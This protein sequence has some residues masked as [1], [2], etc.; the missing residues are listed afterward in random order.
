MPFIIRGVSLL[1]IALG[2]HRARHPRRIWEHLASD[3]KPPHLDTIC[4]R[5][6]TLDEL[7]DVFATHARGRLV[8]AYASCVTDSETVRLAS[9]RSDA[10]LE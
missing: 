2:G 1:G 6:A 3:W 8:R 4:T 10:C 5:E 9:P 7:P